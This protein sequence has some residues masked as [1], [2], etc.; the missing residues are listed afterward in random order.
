MAGSVNWRFGKGGTHTSSRLPTGFIAASLVAL[1]TVCMPVLGEMSDSS[2]TEYRI[3]AAF[4]YNFTSFVNWPEGSAGE[5][6]FTLCILGKNPFGN[7][8]DK[9]A[10]KPVDQA[11]L[12]IKRIDRPEYLESCRLVFIGDISTARLDE[13][14][15]LLHDMPVLTVSDT[16]GFAELGGMIEF[17]IIANKVRFAINNKAAESAGL[18]ISSKLLNLAANFRRAD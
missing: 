2:A 18:S 4:L 15:S 17:R 8:L 1:L 11:R 3:K 10:G 6:G 16:L 5:S 14:L 7:Q 13:T 12:V 9:L